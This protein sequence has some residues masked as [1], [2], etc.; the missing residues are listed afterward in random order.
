[1]RV[2]ILIALIGMTIGYLYGAET[3]MKATEKMLTFAILGGLAI[4][5]ISPFIGLY[6][7]LR[8]LVVRVIR[9]FRPKQ[10]SDS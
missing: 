9:L 5:I 10:R 6:Q 4:T 7:F 3:S 2:I 1:M 8:N